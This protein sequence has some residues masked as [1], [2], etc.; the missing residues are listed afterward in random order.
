MEQNLYHSHEADTTLARQKISNSLKRKANDILCERPTKIIRREIASSRVLN[1]MTTDD[2][3]RFRKNLSAAK[4]RKF[5]NLPTTVFKLHECM[6]TY[7]LKTTT[8]E[9]FVFSP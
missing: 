5:P 4:L 8:D 3:N 9:N 6:R 7:S 2:M 1:V